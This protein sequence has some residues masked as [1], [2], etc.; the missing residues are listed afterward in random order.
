MEEDSQPRN[1]AQR[2]AAARDEAKHTP[3]LDQ[4]STGIKLGQPD[5]SG[6]KG[7]TLYDL[8]AE[9]QAQ[10]EAEGFYEKHGYDKPQYDTQ[11]FMSEADPIG[12]VGEAIVYGITLAMLHFTLDV[13]VFHQYRQ[14]ILWGEIFIKTIK[15]FPGLFFVVYLLHSPTANRLPLLK[16]LFFLA[17]SVTAGCYL[18]YSGNNDGYYEVM[19]R[20]PPIGT[21]WVWS[22]VEMDLKNALAHLVIVA[23]FMWYYGLGN[24]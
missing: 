8:A 14:D 24:F 13:L 20:A 6:P 4:T 16:Q 10:L 7:K 5:R 21:L 1:R 19:K 3:Q 22:V 2:R 17:C 11:Q 15:M 23:A 12:P 18:V 9:R